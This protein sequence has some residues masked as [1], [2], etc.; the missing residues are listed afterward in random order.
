M[1]TATTFYNIVSQTGTRTRTYKNGTSPTVITGCQ[2]SL[3]YMAKSASVRGD[4][5]SPNPWYFRK[6]TSSSVIMEVA[7][8]SEASTYDREFGYYGSSCDTNGDT[9]GG[10]TEQSQFT[11]AYNA[12]A[13]NLSDKV[14]GDLDLS[15]NMFEFKQLNKTLKRLR[16]ITDT[17]KQSLDRIKRGSK[18][19][20][21]EAASLHLEFTY[22]IK[23]VM[24]DAYNTFVKLIEDAKSGT[25]P[26]HFRGR[27]ESVETY[28]TSEDI[29][30]FNVARCKATVKGER[31]VRVQLDVYIKPS[32]TVLQK[33]AGYTSLNPV[34]WA[35]ELMSYSFVLDWFINFGGYLRDLETALLYQNSFVSGCRTD[36]V[37]HDRSFGGGGNSSSHPTM[38]YQISGGNKV[39]K[40]YNRYSIASYPCPKAPTMKMSLSPSRIVNGIALLLQLIDTSRKGKRQ[41]RFKP[42]YR[43]NSSGFYVRVH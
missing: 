6:T 25:T 30:A 3:A 4:F 18:N 31:S 12:A 23:P 29:I 7:Q 42:G 13:A 38:K 28:S 35:Y 15:I 36:T 22:G 14:R 16:N 43:I 10:P 9:P 8:T 33:I 19:A 20:S 24:T 2:T 39:Y 21:K 32:L 41:S 5:K 11:T 1:V 37:L 17:Y 26:L 34:I 40:M 27:G